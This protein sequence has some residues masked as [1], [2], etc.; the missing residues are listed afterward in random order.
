MSV[1]VAPAT[2]TFTLTGSGSVSEGETYTL[3]LSS[4]EPGGQSVASWTINWGDGTTTTLAGNP[5]VAAHVFVTNPADQAT[6]YVVTASGVDA[7]G[8]HAADPLNV[9]VSPASPVFTLS[10]DTTIDAGDDYTVDLV[11]T[12]GAPLV[13][14]TINWGDG[15]STTLLGS[16]TEADHTY[17]EAITTTYTVSATASTSQTTVSAG[18]FALSVTP[19]DPLGTID[20]DTDVDDGTPYTLTLAASPPTGDAVQNLDDQLGRRDLPPKPSAGQ[21]LRSHTRSP[22]AS[23]PM[24]SQPPWLICSAATGTPAKSMSMSTMSAPRR[25]ADQ[26]SP[27]TVNEDAVDQAVLDVTTLFQDL[28][29]PLDQL[30]YSVVNNSDA[31]TL[32]SATINNSNQLVV[33]GVANMYGMSEV[34][35]EAEDPLGNADYTVVPVIVAPVN[36]APTTTGTIPSQ[37]VTSGSQPTLVDLWNYFT[38]REDGSYLTYTIASDSNPGL[39]S[40]DPSIDSNGFLNL[41][42]FQSSGSASLKITAT[43]KGNGDGSGQ[44]SVTSDAFTV[45]AAAPAPTIGFADAASATKGATD[46]GWFTLQRSGGDL[47]QPLTVQYQTGGSAT[48]NVDYSPL[49]GSVTFAANSTTA[50]V[51][52]AALAN[53]TDSDVLTMTITGD[54]TTYSTGASDSIKIW[55]GSGTTPTVVIDASH[56]GDNTGSNPGWIRIDRTE[57]AIGSQLNV[58]YT[59]SGNLLIGGNPP[60]GGYQTFSFDAGDGQAVVDLTDPSGQVGD[61]TGTLTIA[62]DQNPIHGGSGSSSGSGS[63]PH[64]YVGNPYV[65]SVT[66]ADDVDSDVSLQLSFT[67]VDSTT[68]HGG[69]V[70][71]DVDNGYDFGNIAQVNESIDGVSAAVQQPVPDNADDRGLVDRILAGA[72]QLQSASVTLQA[73]GTTPQ[74]GTLTWNIPQGLTV[75]WHG[76]KRT[77]RSLG[78]SLKPPL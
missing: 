61:D 12:A 70:I 66:I 69:G 6:D 4:T 49:S 22:S 50:K 13:D 77:I 62:P 16:Q 74:S 51:D 19:L 35:I 56:N 33:S 3:G 20:G 5:G 54:G 45:T 67:G 7:N 9:A 36:Q 44:S 26:Q 53:N 60:T 39:F 17:A 34:T 40:T 14:W 18:S 48:S 72:G 27:I 52:I 59:F 10:G 57:Q 31:A 71:L 11:Q 15:S 25:R 64:Y 73:I 23:T 38:D 37:T 29:Y 68:Q 24:A 58:Y 43:D 8:S 32:A 21:Q 76:A 55:G 2:P 47:S 28:E 65:A 78:T 63:T 46:G 75:W 1:A 41:E 42:S 30:A